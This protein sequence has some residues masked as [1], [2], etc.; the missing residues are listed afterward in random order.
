[1]LEA[2]CGNLQPDLQNAYLADAV[3]EDIQ[4]LGMQLRLPLIFPGI[5]NS[6]NM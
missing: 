6:R 2:T 4:A 5:S 1:M 3:V